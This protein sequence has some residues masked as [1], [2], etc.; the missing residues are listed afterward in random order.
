MWLQK[1]YVA[2]QTA[3][4][5]YHTILGQGRSAGVFGRGHAAPAAQEN[6][7]VVAADSGVGENPRASLVQPATG[8]GQGRGHVHVQR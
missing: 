6:L 8:A 2:A 3:H 5:F 1:N 7:V 4:S